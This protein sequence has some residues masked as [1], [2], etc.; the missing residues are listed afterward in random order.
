M[1][2]EYYNIKQE[3][4]GLYTCKASNQFGEASCSA[5]LVVF[6]ESVT[7]SREQVTVVQKKGYKVAMTEQHRPVL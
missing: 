5:E 4:S 6:K 7:V 1:L 3:D 2:K